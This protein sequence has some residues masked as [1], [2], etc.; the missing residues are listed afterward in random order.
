MAVERVQ[1]VHG[2]QLVLEVL[3]HAR[4]SS[5]PQ[6]HVVLGQVLVSDTMQVPGPSHGQ[7]WP[8]HEA[9]QELDPRWGLQWYSAVLITYPYTLHQLS[10]GTRLDSCW[11]K[12][13]VY[14]CAHQ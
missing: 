14:S 10:P 5:G 1:P 12:H 8:H 9:R 4:E 13:S 3:V 6:Q 2:D 7:G 11:H